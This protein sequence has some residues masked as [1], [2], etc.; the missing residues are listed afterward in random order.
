MY[1]DYEYKNDDGRDLGECAIA[2]GMGG[3]HDEL[4][5]IRAKVIFTNEARSAAPGSCFVIAMDR[6]KVGGQVLHKQ[7]ENPDVCASTAPTFRTVFRRSSPCA[8][9]STC[10]R[11][12]AV[13]RGGSCDKQGWRGR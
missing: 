3:W 7:N 5:D 6:P 9:S 2:Y 10:A 8:R 13:R 11:S 12:G 1:W 4:K